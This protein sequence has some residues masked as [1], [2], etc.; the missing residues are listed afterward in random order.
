MINRDKR[1]GSVTERLAGASCNC[2][3]LTALTCIINYTQHCTVMKR[4]YKLKEAGFTTAT[5]KG[6]R[7]FL[8]FCVLTLDPNILNV[9]AYFMTELWE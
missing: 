4:G 9:N 1:S 8:R 3:C 6:S 5:G 7:S 2:V